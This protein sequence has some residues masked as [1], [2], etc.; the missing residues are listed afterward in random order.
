MKITKIENPPKE[1]KLFEGANYPVEQELNPEDVASGNINI[2]IN[3][4]TNKSSIRL[5]TAE[6][7][8]YPPRVM[9]LIIQSAIATCLFPLAY[10]LRHLLKKIFIQLIKIQKI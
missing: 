7:I 6:Q 3:N 1:D 2:G 5:T 10:G 8:D 4:L 9:P